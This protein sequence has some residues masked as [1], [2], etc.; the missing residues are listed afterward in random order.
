MFHLMLVLPILICVV[1]MLSVFLFGVFVLIAGIV[2]GT[3][4]ALLIKD[5]VIKR[6]IFISC[7]IVSLVGLICVLPIVS[8]YTEMSK[9]LSLTTAMVAA[10]LCIAALSAF[11]IKCSAAIQK[12]MGKRILKITYWLLLIAAILSAVFLFV[13]KLYLLSL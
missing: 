6:L 10:L 1:I 12:P 5:K 8:A 13:G 4:T 3:S 2:G 7:G 11:G 9:Y